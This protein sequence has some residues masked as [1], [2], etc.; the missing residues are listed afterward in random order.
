MSVDERLVY[1]DNTLCSDCLNSSHKAVEHRN[2][3]VCK[4]NNCNQ[5]HIKFLHVR[6]PISTNKCVVS[7][8]NNNHLFI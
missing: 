7:S 6:V 4:I 8:N 1:V 5:K 2:P 3:F